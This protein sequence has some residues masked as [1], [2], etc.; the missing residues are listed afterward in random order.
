MERVN[1]GEIRILLGK[2]QS[3]CGDSIGGKLFDP[4]TVERVADICFSPL[5]GI[6]LV[7]SFGFFSKVQGL[8]LFQSPCGDSIGGKAK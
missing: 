6:L 3:P 5:A 8:E 7:E 2:F 1:A 4:D